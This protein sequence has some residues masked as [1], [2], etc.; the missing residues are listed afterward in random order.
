MSR[1][2][3]IGWLLIVVS[4]A[5][6]LYF[7]KVRLLEPGP[8]LENKEWVRFIG[9]VLIFLLGTMNVRMA[10]MRQRQRDGLPHSKT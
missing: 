2:K 9:S 1:Q 10:A 3:L 6:V 7:L 4:A 5:Y 8:A